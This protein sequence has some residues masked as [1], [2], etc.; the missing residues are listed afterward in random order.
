MPLFAPAIKKLKAWML[1]RRFE[2]VKY[3]GFVT[4]MSNETM[5]IANHP[6][7]FVLWEDVVRI[8]GQQDSPTDSGGE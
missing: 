7:E 3:R 6:R 8:L 5:T 2:K 1:F 4:T